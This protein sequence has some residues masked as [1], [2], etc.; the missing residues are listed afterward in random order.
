[1]ARRLDYGGKGMKDREIRF[2]G[3]TFLQSECA[4]LFSYINGLGI[5]FDE[6]G[7]MATEDNGEYKS[8]SVDAVRKFIWTD[9]ERIGITN[10]KKH[11]MNALL[12]LILIFIVKRIREGRL[13]SAGPDLDIAHLKPMEIDV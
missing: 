5:L 7:L 8:V 3:Y 6:N 11:E 2:K 9:R 4:K 1:V 10:R 12:R 13:V